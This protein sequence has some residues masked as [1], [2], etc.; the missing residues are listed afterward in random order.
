MEVLPVVIDVA[1]DDAR[2][3]ELPSIEA[4]IDNICTH[5]LQHINYPYTAH[6]TEIFVQCTNDTYVQQLNND[7]RDKDKPTNVL[8]FPGEDLKAG[9]YNNLSHPY[10]ALGDIIIAYDTVKREAEETGISL[11]DHF[12]HMVIHGLLH[13]LGY[14]HIEDDDAKVMEAIEADIL[15]HYHIAN[16]Y[17]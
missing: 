16:P 4:S 14:D 10:I 5:V 2:W 8:S 15:A 17:K 13:L 9:Q 7:H 12:Y 11:H 1:I 6:P 3:N